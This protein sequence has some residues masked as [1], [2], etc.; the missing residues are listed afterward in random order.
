MGCVWLLIIAVLAAMSL[1]GFWGRE[2]WRLD[3]LSH[4]RLQYL[5]AASVLSLLLIWR[6]RWLLLLLALALVLLN[7]VIVLDWPRGPGLWREPALK[8]VSINVYSQNEQVGR[9]V[10]YLRKERPDF[11]ALIEITGKWESEL[12]NLRDLYPFQDVRIYGHNFGSAILSSH[13]MTERSLQ[14]EIGY[15]GPGSIAREV[16]TPSGHLILLLAHPLS[17]ITEKAWGWRNSAFD[18]IAE[19]TQKADE[20]LLLMGDLNCT[21]W[22]PMFQD[23]LA[24]SGLHEPNA[25]TLPRRTWPAGQPWLWIPIDHFLLSPD[26]T[27][28]AEWTGPSVGSDH[29]PIVLIFA[30]SADT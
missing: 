2:H 24:D 14:R 5:T 21:Q 26:L 8:A 30:F 22:S 7:A 6:R 12:E 28:L 13:P 9:I 20:P 15:A 19:F 18:T 3:T 17:P 11:V 27:A 25:R 16:Q 23:F 10:D 1:A 4:F 29:Y